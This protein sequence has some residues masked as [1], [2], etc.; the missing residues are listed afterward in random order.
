MKIRNLTLSALFAALMALC[1]WIQIPT[2]S[3]AFTLQ[4]FALFLTLLLLGGKW[5]SVTV[6]VYLGLGFLGLPVFSGFQGGIGTLLGPSGGFLVGFMLTA[7][8]YGLVTFLFRKSTVSRVFGLVLGLFSCYFTGWLWY[9]RFAPVNFF[10]WCAPF[11]IPDILKLSL[12]FFLAKR[13]NA[14][15][16]PSERT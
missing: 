2:G 7:W 8:A 12:A 15:I 5:G 1:A 3:V 16:S 11:V 4:T 13:I 6:L 14:V 9:C 10:L